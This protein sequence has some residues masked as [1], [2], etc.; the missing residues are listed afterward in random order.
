[1]LTK[2]QKLSNVDDLLYDLLTDH[3]QCYLPLSL[4]TEPR[5]S[6]SISAHLERLK[7]IVHL[8]VTLFKQQGIATLAE[9]LSHQLFGL[10]ATARFLSDTDLKKGLSLWVSEINPLTRQC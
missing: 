7:N 6:D 9:R 10:L 5:L 8:L 3:H 2:H 1:M 4:L